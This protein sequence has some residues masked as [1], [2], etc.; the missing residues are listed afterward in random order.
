MTNIAASTPSNNALLR[1][2]LNLSI[3]GCPWCILKELKKPKLLSPRIGSHL[4]PAYLDRSTSRF[5]N[6]PFFFFRSSTKKLSPDM[7]AIAHPILRLPDRCYE[8]AR[9]EKSTDKPN[10]I[11]KLYDIRVDTACVRS[12]SLLFILARGELNAHVKVKPNLLGAGKCELTLVL[13]P[14][15]F[16]RSFVC[17]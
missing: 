9:R 5:K 6:K 16:F 11:T 12:C 8:F 7:R 4:H 13:Q 2:V 3:D 1:C 10:I 15:I 17:S 14:G